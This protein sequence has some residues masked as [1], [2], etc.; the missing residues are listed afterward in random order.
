M[1]LR[2]LAL[3]Q[4]GNLAVHFYLASN[5]TAQEKYAEAAEAFRKIIDLKPDFA[6]AYSNL[7]STL[8]DQRKYGEAECLAQ[9]PSSSIP[10][11]YRHT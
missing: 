8:V 2:A 9:K 11:S 6:E 5:L 3:Q 1:S 10:I 4:P 7:G